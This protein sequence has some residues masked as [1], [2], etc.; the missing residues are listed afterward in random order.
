MSR[1]GQATLRGQTTKESLM[2]TM[3]TVAGGALAV[4]ASKIVVG[5]TVTIELDVEAFLEEDAS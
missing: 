5:D 1:G 2:S 3:T 4:E